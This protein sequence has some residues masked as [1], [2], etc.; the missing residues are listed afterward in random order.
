MN[1]QLEP[2]FRDPENPSPYPHMAADAFY[3]E[4]LAAHDGL[5]AQGSAMLE[6]K[7]IL[8]LSNHVG[9]LRLLRQALRLAR[10]DVE[11][12][13]INSTDRARVATE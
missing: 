9:D 10:Q 8:L 6:T 3:A 7:L 12:E 13:Q 5:N 1:L 4:L 11:M 2:N